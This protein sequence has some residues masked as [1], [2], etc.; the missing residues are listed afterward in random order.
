MSH[1]LHGFYADHPADLLIIAAALNAL[2]DQLKDNAAH[3]PP[4]AIAMRSRVSQ[5]LGLVETK[6]E[7]K[8]KRNET[9]QRNL[10]GNA[11]TSTAIVISVKAT[12]G[13]LHKSQQMVR[14]DCAS[15]RLTAVKDDHG[16]WL[17]TSE[18]VAAQ[19][20]GI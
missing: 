2:D 4:R 7:T 19:V 1:T 5:L 8:A 14:R 18:S 9:P 11:S 15:G 17:I 12:A 6:R 16:H 10:E 13:V 3:L 20:K